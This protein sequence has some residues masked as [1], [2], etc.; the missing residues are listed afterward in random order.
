MR[1]LL[2]YFYLIWPFI[3]ENA[4]QAYDN[5]HIIPIPKIYLQFVEPLVVLFTLIYIFIDSSV[6]HKKNIKSK[7]ILFLL[8]IFLILSIFTT[9]INKSSIG[10]LIEVTYMFGRPFLVYFFIKNLDVNGQNLFLAL[11]I[12]IFICTLNVLINL[13]Q[14]VS[15]G[16]SGDSAGGLMSH[17]H[18]FTNFIAI[19]IF[20]LVS[21]SFVKKKYKILL[22]TIPLILSVIIAQH[23]KTF[24][25]IP[26]SI[27][28]ILL[29]YS[30]LS[31]K[32]I[33]SGFLVLGLFLFG[34]YKILVTIEPIPTQLFGEVFSHIDEF[35][36]IKAYKTL[37]K[38]FN[39]YK[40]PYVIGFGP[41]NYGS[42]YSTFGRDAKNSDYRPY[43]S[44]I[45]FYSTT[46]GAQSVAGGRLSLW[47]P[48][49]NLFLWV[50]SEFGILGMIIFIYLIFCIVNDIV[51]AVK[52]YDDQ[53]LRAI[54]IAMLMSIT[55]IFALGS[56][57]ILTGFSTQ[58]NIFPIMIISALFT[59]KAKILIIKVK[60]ET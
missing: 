25:I 27:I 17:A 23:Q 28:V 49:T 9:V 52:K 50:I 37:L 21:Y 44:E 42:I 18:T 14:F 45:R 3:W 4:T 36:M 58:G 35:G 20:L 13:W 16:N 29:L 33:L 30:N 26:F 22:L 12:L 47:G 32:K 51:K 41:G 8:L 46:T 15:W 59:N 54:G 6:V 57:Y 40:Y 11:K 53:N 43:S 48:T 24:I 55:F 5:A 1:K 31:L 34:S 56:I 19:F 39:N 60:N 10:A 7:I 38:N 2:F